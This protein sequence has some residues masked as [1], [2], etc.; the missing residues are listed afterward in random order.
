MV[1]RLKDETKGNF[2]QLHTCLGAE[3]L[4][5]LYK[6]Q[7]KELLLKVESCGYNGVHVRLDEEIDE[8]EDESAEDEDEEDEQY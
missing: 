5:L 6:I 3:W 4:P 1:Q 2:R 8:E 7:F